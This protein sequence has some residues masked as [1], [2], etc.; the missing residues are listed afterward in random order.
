MSK[1]VLVVGAGPVGLTM[2]AE[3]ARYGAPVRV[4][5]RLPARNTRSR[6]L[7]IWPR[8]L[9][10]LDAAGCAGAFVATGLHAQA[11][12]IHAGRRTLARIPFGTIASTFNYLLMIP[13]SGAIFP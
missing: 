11:V 10:L 12:S 5:D 13:Q 1:P 7:A 2:A 4:I 6:A 3:L 9:E 8:T